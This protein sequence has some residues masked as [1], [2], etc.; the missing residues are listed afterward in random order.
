MTLMIHSTK[1]IFPCNK[2]KELPIKEDPLPRFVKL[3]PTCQIGYAACFVKEVLLE[4]NHI[5]ALS[6]T[7]L[8]ITAERN[9]CDIDCMT[10]RA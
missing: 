3:L 9:I 2:P 5:C 7:A 10:Y 6:V 1:P 8:T 4:H